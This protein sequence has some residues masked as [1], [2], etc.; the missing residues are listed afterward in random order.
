M[1]PTN[2]IGT[3]S[4]TVTFHVPVPPMLIDTTTFPAPHQTGI[5]D[6]W[7]N[8]YGFEAADITTLNITN[9]TAT[10]PIQVTTETPHGLS[11]GQIIAIPSVNGI[12]QANGCFEITVIDSENFTLNGTTGTGSYEGSYYPSFASYQIAILLPIVSVN[13]SGDSVTIIL[14][15][16]A[17]T[18]LSIGCADTGNPDA[19]DHGGVIQGNRYSNLRDSDPYTGISATPNYNWVC[20]FFHNIA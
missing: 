9:V 13:L 14:G 16:S 7:S 4:V 3:T 10:S 20:E 12:T 1:D 5:L 17:Q 11:T 8:G 18:Q 19:S 15:A 2:G 6:I